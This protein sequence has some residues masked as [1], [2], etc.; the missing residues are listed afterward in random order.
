MGAAKAVVKGFG[1]LK[2]D[3]KEIS[4]V[5]KREMGLRPFGAL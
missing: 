5:K 2:P 3:L 1:F 4:R